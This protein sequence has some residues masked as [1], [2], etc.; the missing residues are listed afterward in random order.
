MILRSILLI[1]SAAT[2]SGCGAAGKDD[3]VAGPRDTIFAAVEDDG[4]LA[5]LDGTTGELLRTVDL[6][7]DARGGNVRFGVHNVQAAPGGRTVWVTASPE[8]DDHTAPMTEQLIGVDTSTARVMSRIALGEGLHVAHVVIRDSLA[9]VT[10]YEAD[11]VLVVDLETE[12]VIRSIHLPSGTRPHG[13]R[14][15]PD[16]IILVVAGMGDGS[17]HTVH[18]GTGYVESHPLPGRAVQTAVLPDGSAAF[19]TV[20]D[21]RQVARLDLSDGTLSLFDLP[22]GAAGP[23]QLYP[24]PDASL[25]IADQGMLDGDEAGTRLYRMR[26]IDGTV[27]LSVDVSPAPHGVVVNAESGTVWTTTLV[28]GSVQAIDG[29]SG[30]VI[31]STPV[32]N[33]P[34]GITCVHGGGVMP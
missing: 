6:S 25:W 33:G 14:L 9:Y 31:W 20:Y 30:Q 22:A 32:G 4:T 8:G 2:F 24:A 5:E 12:R 3:A 26:V 27:D 15:T 18:T 13:A 23:V 19:V 28:E 10:A 7:R 16:G 11:L 29:E 34:N 17:V 1:A 21:T